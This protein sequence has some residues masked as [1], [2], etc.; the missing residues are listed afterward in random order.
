MRTRTFAVLGLLLG[1][2]AA[3]VLA[4]GPHVVQGQ[5]PPQPPSSQSPPQQAPPTFR[6][7]VDLVAV[8]VSVVDSTGRPVR[9]LEARDFQLKVDGRARRIASVQYV[10][11]EIAPG[12]P[13]S[14]APTVTPFSSNDGMGGGRL[15]MVIV[16]QGNIGAGSGRIVLATISRFL[17]RLGPGDRAALA[18][19]P[20]GMV[21]NFTRHLALVR[22]GVGKVMGTNVPIG[23]GRRMG[24]SEALAIERRDPGALQDVVDRECGGSTRNPEDVVACTADVI[25]EASSLVVTAKSQSAVS[26]TALRSLVRRLAAIEGPKTLI[27]VSEGL[28]I[29]RQMDLLSWVSDETAQARASV[30]ALRIIPPLFDVN[31]ERQNYSAALDQ[32][33]A[34]LGLEML[35]G[36]ARGAFYSVIGRGQSVFDRLSLEMTG[37]YLLGFEPESTDRNGKS[38]NI[39]VTVSRPGVSVRARRQFTAPPPT[40]TT[41]SD[42][43][44]I[45]TILAQPL[46]AGDIPLKVTTRSFKDPS[47]EKIKLIVAASIGR[48][49]D[50]P[51]TRALG[52]MVTD[53]RGE[54]QSLTVDT[55]PGSSREYMGA[56]IISPGTYTLKLAAIDE[57]GRRGSVEHRF[58]ARLRVGGPFRFGDLTLAD[59]EVGRALQLKIEPRV[60]RQ[61]VTAYTEIYASD[62]VRFEGA[63]VMFEVA[64]EPNG[65]TLASAAGVLAETTSPG[66]RLVQGSVP[67][68][69]LQPGDYVLRA[70][71][72][73]AGRPVA[74]LTTEFALIAGSAGNAGPSASGSGQVP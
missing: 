58:D 26:L 3:A 19:L 16:D 49:A 62:P 71:V 51:Q 11:Q 73:V 17:S 15:V 6:T 30:Y 12:T 60:S 54:I 43:E 65:P 22:D 10:S 64:K 35:V 18:I 2:S 61:S 33:L 55:S 57:Q 21:V 24:L 8:D 41:P 14:E 50:L 23:Q 20:G 68:S 27:L 74:R 36:R 69:T 34:A 53:D 7:G 9:E 52:F 28:V 32:D 31:D 38:H 42:D 25:A 72:A 46:L 70:I 47:S 29:D 1:A 59:G 39:G 45:K 37:Y 66:R 67:V 63:S 13:L 5:Q 44:I 56:A 40:N 4:A 48:P